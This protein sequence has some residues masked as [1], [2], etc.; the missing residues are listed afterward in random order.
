MG[1]MNADEPRLEEDSQQQ[2]MDA[3]SAR[4]SAQAAD[5]HALQARADKANHRSDKSEH[6]AYAESRRMDSVE[7]RL[8][9]DE[10]ILVTLQAEGVLQAQH[11]A[12]LHEA[13]RS[14][15]LIGAALGII[16]ENRDVGQAEAFTILSKASQDSNRK[17]RVIA[18]EIVHT[19]QVS[20][21]P[22]T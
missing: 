2:Q 4:V 17:V 18:D 10:A 14:A 1:F 21:L 11:A 9:V 19:R 12:H 8:D 22:I 3:L 5:I 7:A 13:L 15:R 20:A 6:L 16:M